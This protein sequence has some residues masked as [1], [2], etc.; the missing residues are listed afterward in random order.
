M[1]GWSD[2]IISRTK[3]IHYYKHGVSL[4]GRKPLD[5]GNRLFDISPKTKSDSYS[6][7]CKIC[8]SKQNNGKL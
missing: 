6:H 8:I 5:K 1:E 3:T 2:S 7:Y 4:C